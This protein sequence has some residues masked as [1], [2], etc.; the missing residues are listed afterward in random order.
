MFGKKNDFH[1]FD[2]G[3]RTI[4][5]F[6]MHCYCSNTDIFTTCKPGDR[7]VREKVVEEV[8]AVVHVV[9]L[10][11]VKHNKQ[12]K[13]T[14]LQMKKEVEKESKATLSKRAHLKQLPDIE[15]Y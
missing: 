1:I 5:T 3:T 13:I 14:T 6:H 12:Q 7:N 15:E 9:W 2:Q 8:K 11:Y 4:M 10:D